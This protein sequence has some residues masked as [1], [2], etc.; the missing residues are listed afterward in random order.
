MDRLHHETCKSLVE[1]TSSR[2]AEDLLHLNTESSESKQES[3]T[4]TSMLIV[5]DD[6]K[7]SSD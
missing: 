3:Q 4:A 1:E 7:C 5:I 6:G 2:D